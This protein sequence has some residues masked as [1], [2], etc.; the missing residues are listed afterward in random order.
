MINLPAFSL[1]SV[2]P[3][4]DLVSTSEPFPIHYCKPTL[5]VPQCSLDLP[6]EHLRRTCPRCGFVWAEACVEAS[7]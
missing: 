2:C 6:V 5:V 7:P 3:K 1:S 4:C